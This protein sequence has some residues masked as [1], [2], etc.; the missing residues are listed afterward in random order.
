MKRTMYLVIKHEGSEYLGDGWFDADTEHTVFF[1]EENAEKYIREVMRDEF[2]KLSKD[3]DISEL[4]IDEELN[5]I[6]YYN[7]RTSFG[8]IDEWNIRV[9]EAQDEEV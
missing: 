7:D 5:T 6:S 3:A 9:L 8:R 1:K 2:E 4:E